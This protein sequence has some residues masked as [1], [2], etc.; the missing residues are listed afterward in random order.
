M[1]SQEYNIS[2]ARYNPPIVLQFQLPLT[3]TTCLSLPCT[4]TVFLV[5]FNLAA[6]H[7]SA[8][9]YLFLCFCC[10]TSHHRLCGFMIRS[11]VFT[12]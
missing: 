1:M 6:L 9:P 8:T 3:P 11:L 12:A 4:A 7:A 10:S 2:I 5:L